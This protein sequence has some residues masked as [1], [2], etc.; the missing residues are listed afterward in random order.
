MGRGRYPGRY[1]VRATVPRLHQT[2]S[3][4]RSCVPYPSTAR[5]EDGLAKW[6]SANA[7]DGE[8]SSGEFTLWHNLNHVS[9]L[10]GSHSLLTC[11]GRLTP[12]QWPIQ[13]AVVR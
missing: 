5:W 9:L 2:E 1:P 4:S 12:A 6:L 11:A 8:A 10:P 13:Y 3:D 7:P